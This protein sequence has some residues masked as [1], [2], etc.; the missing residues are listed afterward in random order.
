MRILIADDEPVTRK[1]LQRIL[2]DLGH[3]V[4]AADNGQRALEILARDNI[5]FVIADWM[6]PE[7]DGLA[8]CRVV[9]SLKDRGYIYFMLLT[10]R[11]RKEDTIIGLDAGADDYVVKPFERNELRVRVRAGERILNLERE[12]QEKNECMQGL[13]QKLE[14]LARTDPLMGIGNRLGFYETIEKVHSLGCRYAYVYGIIMCDI[15]HFKSYNDTYGHPAG[16]YVLKRIANSIRT[17]LRNSDEC[18]R[19]GGEEIVIVLR[20][21]NL[22][23][24]LAV[25]EKIRQGV[26]ALGIWNKAVEKG[27]VTIS[28]GVAAYDMEALHNRWEDILGRADEALYR[29]KTAGRNRVST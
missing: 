21:Q 26:E 27:I 28:C 20:D 19:Y 15:D 9:R 13:N 23:N 8:L 6:M 4:T 1:L 17:G 7:M 16:D 2:E 3:E 12:L 22:N 14:E 29:A 10:G 5:K 18:F 24:T 11:D 25:A